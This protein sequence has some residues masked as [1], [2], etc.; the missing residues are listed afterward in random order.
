MQK[1]KR[2]RIREGFPGQRVTVIPEDVEQRCRLLPMVRHLY[3]TDL[4]SY[5]SAP[6]HY[7]KRKQGVS[8]AVLIYCSNGRGF[9]TIDHTTHD[10]RRGH[11]TV[12]PPETPHTYQADAFEPWSIFWIHFTGEQTE[13]LLSSM[14]VDANRPGLYVP[15]T[16]LMQNAFEDVYACLNYHYS[17]AG[18]LAMT[19]ELLRLFSLAKLHLSFPNP[20]RQSAENRIVAS[21]DFMERHLNLSLSVKELATHAGQSI[22][23]YSRLFKERT[24]QSPTAFF[25]QLKVRKACELLDQTDLSVREIAGELGYDDPYYFSRIFKKVQGKSPAHYRKSLKG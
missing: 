6:N 16:R 5:P 7:V 8:S 13:S 14:G 23:Y 25:I 22:P 9:L 20:Q 17:N 4:G 24:N 21:Q 15:D 18:L 1:P 2:P 3:I 10:I 19:S 11:L 12:I